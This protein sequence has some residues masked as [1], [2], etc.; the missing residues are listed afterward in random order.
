MQ[1]TAHYSAFLWFLQ[2]GKTNRHTNYVLVDLFICQFVSI[3][4]KSGSVVTSKIT[5]NVLIS[6]LIYC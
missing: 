5:G 6:L 1:A 2:D 4:L 3:Q